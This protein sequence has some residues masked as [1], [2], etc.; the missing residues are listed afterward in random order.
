[1]KLLTGSFERQGQDFAV[2]LA[3]CMAMRVSRRNGASGERRG[4]YVIQREVI[5]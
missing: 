1:M 3:L 2:M 5:R 4:V